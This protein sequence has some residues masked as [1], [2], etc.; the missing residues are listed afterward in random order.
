MADSDRSYVVRR[1]D[2]EGR[3]QYVSIEEF[4]KQSYECGVSVGDLLQLRQTLVVRDESG[5]E[6]GER[7]Q[8]GEVWVVLSG[9]Y[10]DPE[11]VWLRQPDG[12][13]HSWSNDGSI[14]EQFSK[15]PAPAT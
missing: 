1:L 4:N 11:V 6:T 3:E 5:S 2:P 15:C 13:L 9:S 7:H 12:E 8:A 10:Q 14:W